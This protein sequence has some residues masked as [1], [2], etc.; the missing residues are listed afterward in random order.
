MS[1]PRAMTVV[2]EKYPIS[3][4]PSTMTSPCVKGLQPGRAG[5]SLAIVVGK[6]GTVAE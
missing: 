6:P 2:S 3:S 5:P 1:P 4:R